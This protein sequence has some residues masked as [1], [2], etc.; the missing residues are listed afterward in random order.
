MFPS[1]V[2]DINTLDKEFR[3]LKFSEFDFSVK[4]IEFWKQVS[5]TKKG[6]GSLAFPELTKFIE[7]LLSLPHSSAAAE[8]LFFFINLNKTK[9]RNRLGATT[10][11]GLLHS[12]RLLIITLVLI[13]L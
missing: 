5:S 10:I 12:K 2:T 6:D 1:M 11:S 9:L 7:I 3:Q 4:D 13:F 8:R